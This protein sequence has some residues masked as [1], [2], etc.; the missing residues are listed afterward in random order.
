MSEDT[1]KMTVNG[2]QF[3]R[4]VI[5]NIAYSSDVIILTGAV[6]DSWWRKQGH[7]LH[8]EDLGEVVQAR[9]EVLVVGTGYYGRMS[10]PQE[11]KVFLESEGI[12][13]IEAR[14]AEAVQKFNELS[15]GST[16]VVAALHLTC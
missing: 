3:G 6:E 13:L 7:S 2:Y 9:P 15:D 1:G 10:I 8:R 11:T 16:K 12:Q 5:E 4:I 14:T